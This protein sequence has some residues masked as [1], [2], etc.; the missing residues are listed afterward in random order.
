L[1]GPLEAIQKGLQEIDAELPIRWV[2]L[3]EGESE[4]AFIR[5][6]QFRRTGM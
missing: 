3:V 4:E 2:A 5:A 1:I 6:I